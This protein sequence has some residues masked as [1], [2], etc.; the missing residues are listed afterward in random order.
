M[1]KK[2]LF[3][4]SMTDDEGFYDELRRIAGL[5]PPPNSVSC[6]TAKSS[7]SFIWADMTDEDE[8]T[9][10]AL[11]VHSSGHV[12]IGFSTRNKLIISKDFKFNEA[13]VI[14]AIELTASGVFTQY[15]DSICHF[16][17]VSNFEDRD[18]QVLLN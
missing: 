10:L 17:N 14:E 3:E 9:K 1:K 7:V 2:A 6:H 16:L 5:L 11:T 4:V 15:P 8:G 18:Q 12:M 13:P